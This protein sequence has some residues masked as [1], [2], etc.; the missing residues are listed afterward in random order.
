[1]IFSLAEVELV[2]DEPVSKKQKMDSTCD[3]EEPLDLVKVFMSEFTSRMQ[4]K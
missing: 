3:A 1:M 4:K 2:E